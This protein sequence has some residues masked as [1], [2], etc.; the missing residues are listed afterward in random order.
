[1]LVTVCTPLVASPRVRQLE[2]LFDMPA[3]G[4]ALRRWQVNLPLAERPW[5]VG[6]VLGPSGCGKSTIA[7]HLWPE[8]LAAP[9]PWPGDRAVV[10]AFPADLSIKEIAL[11]LS[12]VGFSSPPAWRLPFH[13]LSTGQQYR[14]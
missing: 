2:G 5:H 13:V 3:G 8:A 12:S 9:E 10:D 1:M 14:V 4:S 6:L 7:R 11:L